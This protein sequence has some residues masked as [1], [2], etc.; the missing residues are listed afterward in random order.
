MHLIRCRG[1]V[2][3]LYLYNRKKLKNKHLLDVWKC[4]LG[5]LEGGY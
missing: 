2:C 3:P 1:E 4:Y 5:Q